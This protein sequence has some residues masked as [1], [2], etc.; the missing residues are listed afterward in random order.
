MTI[1][2]LLFGFLKLL[3][4]SGLIIGQFVAYILGNRVLRLNVSFKYKE[5]ISYKYKDLKTVLH[6]YRD[7]P[8]YAFPAGLANATTL[9]ISNLLITSIY[10]VNDVGQFS[11]ANRIIGAPNVLIAQSVSQVLLSKLVKKLKIIKLQI[12]FYPH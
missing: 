6:R 11:L 10:S 12:N 2:Q 5:M 8:R 7:F 9:N 1:V 4:D 3:L